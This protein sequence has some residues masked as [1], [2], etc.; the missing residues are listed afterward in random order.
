V[1]GRP[2]VVDPRIVCDG[3]VLEQEAFAAMGERGDVLGDPVV[4]P[5]IAVNASSRRPV[6][7]EAPNPASSAARVR[8]AIGREKNSDRI[9]W[10]RP[11]KSSGSAKVHF[12]WW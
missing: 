4:R 1:G 8:S 9:R 5:P 3:D 6:V 2:G 11:G 7:V 10:A 12:R